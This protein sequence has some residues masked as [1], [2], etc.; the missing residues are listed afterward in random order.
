MLSHAGY[1]PYGIQ[2]NVTADTVKDWGWSECYHLSSTYGDSINNTILP[3][4]AGDYLMMGFFDKRTNTYAILGGG[5]YSVVTSFVEASLELNSPPKELDNWS[6][7]LNF[8]RIQTSLRSAWGFTTNSKIKMYAYYDMFLYNDYSSGEYNNGHPSTGLSLAASVHPGSID[9][10]GIYNI[11]G[12]D[13]NSALAPTYKLDTV[14][15]TLSGPI[16]NP[17]HGTDPGITPVTEPSSLALFGL[18]IG[19]MGLASRRRRQ[20]V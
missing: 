11:N 5:E 15:L 8:Y 1:L 18:G 17:P 7:G 9:R 3:R 16:S 4:C 19:G 14:F 6:N 13:F 2:S 10:G 20:M 12:Y